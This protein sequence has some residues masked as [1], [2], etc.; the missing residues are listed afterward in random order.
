MFSWG[1]TANGRLGLGRLKSSS[2]DTNETKIPWCQCN[3]TMIQNLILEDI[4][5]VSAGTKHAL[6]VTSKGDVYAWGSNSAGE[7]SVMYTASNN[8]ESIAMS[9]QSVGLHSIDQVKAP[10]IWDDVWVPRK[11]TYFGDGKAE[12]QAKSVAAGGSHSAVVDKDGILYSW[13]GG[14]DNQC[15]GHGDSSN[16][17]YGIRQQTDALQRQ[18]NTMSGHLQSPPWAF[19]RIMKGLRHC[20]VSSVSLGGKHGAALTDTNM[21]YVWGKQQPDIIKVKFGGIGK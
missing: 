19:P 6:A 13:G 21:I 16:Y 8:T 1:L 4:I 5:D 7:C 14:G 18:F 15:L 2:Y 9:I 12:I 11:I 20:K 17:E 3:P 10:T